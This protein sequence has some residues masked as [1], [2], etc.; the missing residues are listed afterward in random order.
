MSGP[1]GLD[2]DAL[3]RYLASV[4]VE[5]TGPLQAELI[6]GGR[7]NLTYAVTDGTWRWAVRRPPLAGLTASA[8][9]MVREWRVTS[10]LQATPV[11]VARPVSL[12]TDESVLGA[13]FTVVEWVDGIVVRDREDL[14]ALTDE[15]VRR[16]ME[17]LVEVLVA[18][19]AVNVAGAGLAGFGRPQGIP[20]PP[21]G[22]VVAPMGA[23]AHAGAAGPGA[24]ARA[25][26]RAGA[27]RVSG[28]PWCTATTGSTTRSSTEPTRSSSA[29]SSTGS[30][31][32]SA[33]RS[34]TSR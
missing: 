28:Q 6:A 14:R 17:A 30:C 11:P 26:G 8:H 7:S 12:C 23:H 32:R 16:T 31:P 15:Q 33:I 9:D 29:R 25:A 4:G 19:R 27:G 24:A 18:L 1:S 3:G 2:L 21:G 34:P 20:H 13:P 22:L 5:L 10:A